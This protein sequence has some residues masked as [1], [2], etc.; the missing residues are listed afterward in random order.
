MSYA[1]AAAPVVLA[2]ILGVVNGQFHLPVRL[3]NQAHQSATLVWYAFSEPWKE[4][5]KGTLG[6][7]PR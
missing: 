6:A 1:R 4:Q 2:G 3:T 5:D 7:Q